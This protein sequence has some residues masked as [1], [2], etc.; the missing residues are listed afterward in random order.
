M[1]TAIGE[2]Y[3]IPQSVCPSPRHTA[4]LGYRR[5][6]C[7]QLSHVQ[8]V[9]PKA[10]GCRSTVS[11]TAIG[12]GGCIWSRCRQDNNLFD[13]HQWIRC[14][15]RMIQWQLNHG[16]SCKRVISI[17]SCLFS[18]NPALR[19]TGQT[20][21]MGVSCKSRACVL[22]VCASW[23][24]AECSLWCCCLADTA[25]RLLMFLTDLPVWPRPTCVLMTDT[26]TDPPRTSS[27]LDP[28]GSAVVRN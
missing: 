4:T 7:L 10:G 27:D 21:L 11:Q 25:C 22:T 19:V 18:I 9:D 6:G 26:G 23:L 28:S 15:V 3:A 13:Y 14:S 16:R 17:P 5:A 1:P 12:G 8:T 24:P 20:S 2:H